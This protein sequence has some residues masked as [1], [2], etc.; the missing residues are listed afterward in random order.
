M[1]P[2]DSR[3]C[4]IYDPR[5]HIRTVRNDVIVRTIQPTDGEADLVESARLPPDTIRV[6]VATATHF[7]AEMFGA[8]GFPPDH[9]A[10]VADVLVSADLRGVRSH[11]V[12]RIGYFMVRVERGTINPTP[13]F[14]LTNGSDT[15]ALL[16]ADNGIGIVASAAAMDHALDMARRHGSGFVA[17]SDS[18]HFGFAGYWAERAMAQGCVG[19]S[20]SNSAGRVTPTFGDASLLGTNPMSVAIGGSEDGTDFVLDMATSTV[21]VGKVETALREGGSIPEGWLGSGSPPRLDEHGV[22]SYDAPLL[23]LGGAGDERGGHKGYGLNLM[24]ELICGALSGTPFADRIAGASGHTPAAMAHFMGAIRIGGF[25]PDADVHESIA[26]TLDIVRDADKAPG[27]DR[28]YI[29]G[30]PERLA[31]RENSEEGLAIT[32]PVRRDIARAATA[33]RVDVPW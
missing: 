18:N 32:A 27:H 30:E 17:V 28:I 7:V 9:A 26:A 20:M 6:P 15:T 24:V 2:F 12:A 11:G 14:T 1:I 19:I 13:S 29:H 5:H 33:L 3:S 4:K 8:A 31:H 22:L 21:A 25:R 23:P 16:E 10:L